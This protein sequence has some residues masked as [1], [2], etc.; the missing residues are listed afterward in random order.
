MATLSGVA[1]LHPQIAYAGLQKSLQQKCAFVKRV[2]SEIGMEFQGVD[3]ALQEI[4]L[5]YLFQ[6]SMAQIP[7]RAIICL[8][9]T[10]AG[11]ALP[12]PTWTAGE[13][14]TASCIITGYLVA[15][16]H[17][18]AKFRLGDHALIMAEGTEVICQQSAEEAETS[19]G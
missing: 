5:S 7:E 13:N 11:I 4:L 16:F 3:N 14:W 1:R 8:T 10:Q 6:G 15:A 9:V 12:D 2:T 18:T 17:G 19:L